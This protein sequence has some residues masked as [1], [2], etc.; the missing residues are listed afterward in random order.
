MSAGAC[1][2]LASSFV[3]DSSCLSLATVSGLE[4]MVW[5]CFPAPGSMFLHVEC[6]LANWNILKIWRHWACHTTL[7][8][9]L[10]SNVNESGCC[11]GKSFLLKYVTITTHSRDNRSNS[12]A[13]AF[14]FLTTREEK[15]LRGDNYPVVCCW[16]AARSQ[17]LAFKSVYSQ[18]VC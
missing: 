17:A 10:P 4:K 2:A 6:L 18:I 16:V 11:E 1:L 14:K 3:T 8:R 5:K 12:Q 7:D 13:L 9:H 15:L